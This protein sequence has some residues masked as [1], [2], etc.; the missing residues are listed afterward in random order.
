MHVMLMPVQAQ[1]QA[2]EKDKA[3]ETLQLAR[4]LLMLD[5][6]VRAE[7]SLCPTSWRGEL[8]GP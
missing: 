4:E 1:Q 6:K 8:G 5:Y 3:Q 7:E 2:V